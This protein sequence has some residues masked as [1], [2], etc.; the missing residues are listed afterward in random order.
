MTN[1]FSS[2]ITINDKNI[3]LT[4]EKDILSSSTIINENAYKLSLKELNSNNYILVI[5]IYITIDK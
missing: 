3:T 4:L 5:K 1:L 2:N